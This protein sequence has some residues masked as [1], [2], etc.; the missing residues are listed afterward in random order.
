MVGKGMSESPTLEKGLLAEFIGTFMFVFVGA[1]SSV[2]AF[3]VF[4][5]TNPSSALL[6]IILAASSKDDTS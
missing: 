3:V 4:G 2:G 5:N 1:G 6:R